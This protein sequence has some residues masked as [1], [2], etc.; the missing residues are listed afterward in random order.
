[1]WRG[2]RR[3]RLLL[4]DDEAGFREP[5]AKRLEKR[6]LVVRTAADG[7]QAMDC[8]ARDSVDV[9]VMDVKMPVMDGLKALKLIGESHPKTEV[10]LITG[11]SSTADGVAGI[12]AGAFDYL[13]KPLDIDHLTGK[14]HQAFDRVMRQEAEAREADYRA[15]M[16][17]RFIA[18]ERL[19]SLGTLSTGVAHEINNPLAVIAEAVG[20]LK[21][22]A[23][24]E[25][26]LPEG[27][28]G[29]L[30]LAL[31][32]MEASVER[33]RRITHQ[34]L[35]FARQGET[36]IQ[37]FDLCELAAEA[38]ELTRKGAAEARA[39]VISVCDA[40]RSLVWSDP[41]QIRQ[42]LINLTTNAVQA[43]EPGGRV[44]IRVGGDSQNIMVSVSDDGPGIPE[45]NLSRIFEP[46][47][48][49]KPPGQ[50]TGLGLSV[51]RGLVDK[52]GGRI[53]VDSRLGHGAVFRII[54]P[55]RP[56]QRPDDPSGAGRSQK[57]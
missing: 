17:Q 36:T 2:E 44:E 12:K 25:S 7:R 20:W 40:Q 10:I 27:F 47:F 35:G 18:A 1:M 43:V 26:G 37:E 53:D 45:E 41:Y 28:R 19:A 29:N 52:L 49:T 38:I 57:E 39:E 24:R 56:K 4:V 22:R 46:F 51:S 30:E 5:L 32:K 48:S 9:V 15:R 3:I 54:I 33:A 23:A 11:R 31:S 8:L 50:G 16:E 14:I 42:V 6:G 34:L 13:S 55:R 21:G